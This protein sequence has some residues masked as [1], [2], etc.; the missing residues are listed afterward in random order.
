MKNII[1]LLCTYLFITSCDV[2]DQEPIDSVSTQE[3]FVRPSDAEAAII[4]TYR[5]LANTGLNYVVFAELPTKNTIGNALNRQFEQLN[6]LIFVA[7]NSQFS[8]LWDQQYVLVNSANVVIAKVPGIP[9]MT[10]AAKSS[11]IAEARFMRAFTYFN[12]VRYFGS[13]PLII[14]PT[15]SPDVA[16]LQVPRT[17]IDAIYK[18]ILEDL[19]FAKLNLPEAHAGLGRTGRATKAAAYALGARIHLTRKNWALA[20]ADANQVISRRGESLTVAYANLF[21]TKNSAE[22]IFEIN[23]DTQ[24]QNALATTFLPASLSGT[25]TIQ[26]NPNLVAAYETGDARKDATIGF[27][28]ADN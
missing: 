25:R 2:I 22:S 1:P 24:L 7:D 15:E 21:L 6:N 16:A 26:I 19:D 11:I 23:Y 3:L 14:M 4:G 10:D 20:I 5:N 27:A 18:Q 9:G 12:L 8:N 17:S 13:V 28:N